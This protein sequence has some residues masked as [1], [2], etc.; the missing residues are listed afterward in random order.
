MN[1]ASKWQ[2][3]SCSIKLT[4]LNISLGVFTWNIRLTIKTWLI[5][6]SKSYF[7][8]SHAWWQCGDILFTFYEESQ[9]RKHVLCFWGKIPG[10]IVRF[11]I[12]CENRY[13]DWLGADNFDLFSYSRECTNF[14]SC[15]SERENWKERSK[16]KYSRIWNNLLNCT[17]HE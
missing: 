4:P 9:E 6:C 13:K 1:H 3:T 7:D 5:K 12:F 10:N 15:I 14:V 11:I 17:K 8:L 2:Y 16:T